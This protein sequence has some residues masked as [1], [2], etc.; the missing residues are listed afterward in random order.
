V[1]TAADI[2]HTDLG[3]QH[4]IAV[5]LSTPEALESLQN[6]PNIEYVEQDLPR[7]PIRMRG[8]D[9]N[10][11][12]KQHMPNNNETRVENYRKLT[13]SVPYGIPMVQADQVSYDSNNPR[14]ICIIDS[15]YD[16]GHED[17]PSTNV[18]GFSFDD[19][20][21]PWNQDG[22]GHGTHVAG[23]SPINVIGL[24][25]TTRDNEGFSNLAFLSLFYRYNRCLLGQRQGCHRSC[26]RCQFIY[27][28]NLCRRWVGDSRFE[29][30]GCCQQVQS[31]WRQCH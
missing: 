6:D 25:D 22:S 14:K 3:P 11:V 12:V 4:A 31:W 28:S 17:L 9:S 29:C 18:D 27:C 21:Y 5:T 7:F 1:H 19:R 26:S 2:C 30:D 20:G 24:F 16:L 8:Y 23:R 15:G 10:D 13:E